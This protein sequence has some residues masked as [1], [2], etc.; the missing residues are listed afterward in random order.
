MKCAHDFLGR[1]GFVGHQEQAVKV[2]VFS[3]VFWGKGAS[4][5]LQ[6]RKPLPSREAPK[7]SAGLF[8]IRQNKAMHI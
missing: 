6:K 2:S 4:E 8:I 7:D 1:I 3:P 5:I